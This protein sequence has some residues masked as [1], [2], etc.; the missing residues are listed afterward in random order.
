MNDILLSCRLPD[1]DQLLILD[2]CHAA[3][4][5]GHE[6]LGKRKFEM[7]V[8]S[9]CANK[10]P[11]PHQ[12][13]SFT[14][15]L[16]QVLTKLLQENKAGF[17]TSQL[18]REI[19]HSIPH[20]VK[21]WLFDQARRDY[22]R[23]WLRP[24]EA[25]AKTGNLDKESTYLNL[26]LKLNKKPDSIV[27]H[28]LALSLQYLPYIDIVRL[29]KLYAPRKQMDDFV[30]FARRA[31]RLQPLVRRIH[32]KRKLKELRALPQGEQNF[33]RPL[34]LIKLYLDQKHSPTFDWASALEGHVP[35]PSSPIAPRRKKS[36]T[37]PPVEVE[38]SRKGTRGSNRFFSVDYKFALPGKPSIPGIFQPRRAMTVAFDATSS[39]APAAN[40]KSS[41]YLDMEAS[42]PCTH[43][44]P[45]SWTA[46]L[47]YGELWH[48]CMWLTLC[49]TLWC[50]CY[51][52]KE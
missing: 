29:E 27:M 42:S 5:F 40:W 19:Y 49:Y 30:L 44:L 8:S 4:A 22:G 36:S 23:I 11:A 35:T 1:C 43:D 37:W 15:S 17:V 13:G 10:V 16:K 46:L 33:Q 6:H 18:Y 31:A 9:G 25:S 34:S 45:R 20:H 47:N 50:F 7:I 24:Q 26:T 12:P 3:N 51:H 14:K 32:Q 39:K 21:P 28:Q 52:L 48:T 38:A 41:N 2:C